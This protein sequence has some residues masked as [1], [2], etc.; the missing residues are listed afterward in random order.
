MRR[1][2]VPGSR[3]EHHAQIY[4]LVNGLGSRCNGPAKCGRLSRGDEKKQ[5][6][7]KIRLG[8]RTTGR[9]WCSP[10][11][12]HSELISVTAGP[13]GP[14][15]ASPHDPAPLPVPAPSCPA[16]A[17]NS[18]SFGAE[19]KGASDSDVDTATQPHCQAPRLWLISNW[20][21]FLTRP[22]RALPID[23]EQITHARNHDEQYG[24]ESSVCKEA[25]AALRP[26]LRV[27]PVP[28]IY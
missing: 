5:G 20:T 11:Q 4:R 13:L 25:E 9:A 1:E 6:E 16:G 15:R 27:Q 2:C 26:G 12:H 8:G 14:A 10:P 28:D 23:T 21:A 24:L 18:P 7:G 22:Q 3:S 19:G 17:P